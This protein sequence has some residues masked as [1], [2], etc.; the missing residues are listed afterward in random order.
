MLTWQTI[1]PSPLFVSWLLGSHLGLNWR[2]WNGTSTSTYAHCAT[3]LDVPVCPA[4][5]VHPDRSV[6]VYWRRLVTDGRCGVVLC[7]AIV[8]SSRAPSVEDDEDGHLIYRHGDVLQDRCSWIQQFVVD[9]IID[10]ILSPDITWFP[11]GRKK[12][13][14]TSLSECINNK[15]HSFSALCVLWVGG[16]NF[17]WHDKDFNGIRKRIGWII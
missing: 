14:Y 13:F 3:W 6:G 10:S 11:W 5:P 16:S 2:Q 1:L 17:S 12:H 4:C 7:V 15:Y 9:I 8:Q